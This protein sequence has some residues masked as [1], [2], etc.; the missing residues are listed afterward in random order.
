MGGVKGRYL[1]DRIKYPSC[2]RR[3]IAAHSRVQSVRTNMDV[4]VASPMFLGDTNDATPP[5]GVCTVERQAKLVAMACVQIA[6]HFVVRGGA[7]G[8][9]EC[10]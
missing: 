1:Y 6:N 8:S 2:G 7:G 10:L 4:G 9:A 5:Y 3:G